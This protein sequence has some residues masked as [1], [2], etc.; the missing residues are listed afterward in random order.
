MLAGAAFGLAAGGVCE[1]LR[2]AD[3]SDDGVGDGDRERRGLQ[4]VD[5]F[6]NR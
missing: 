2:D 1:R 4:M 3:D 6:T 5:I